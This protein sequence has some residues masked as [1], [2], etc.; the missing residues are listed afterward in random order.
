MEPNNFD[1][2]KLWPYIAMLILAIL[3]TFSVH[4][5]SVE[6]AAREATVIGQ[7]TQQK[8]DDAKKGQGAVTYREKQ[9]YPNIDDRLAK[10]E[11]LLKDNSDRNES[12]TKEDSIDTIAHKLTMLGYSTAVAR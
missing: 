4:S 12:E 1:L 11:K 9:V 6:K 8:I 2:K 10:I 5:C 7:A 3:L